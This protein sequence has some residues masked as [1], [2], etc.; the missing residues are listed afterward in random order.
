MITVLMAT[1]NGETTLPE[2]LEAFCELE[3]PDGAWKLVIVDNGSTDHTKEIIASFSQCLPLTYLFESR[4]GKNAALNTGLLSV[5]GDLVVF[6]DDDVFPKP[7][8]LKHIRSAADSHLSFSIFGGPI[9]PKWESPPED[10]I[11]EWVDLG[12]TFAI[13]FPAE[14]GPFNPHLVWGPNMAIR[15]DIFR[16]GYRFDETMGPKGPNYTMGSETALILRLT[17]AGFK[18]WHCKRAVVHH[19]IQS[20]QMTQD[21][22][23]GR[24]IRHGRGK[25][26]QEIQDSPSS[27]ALL[28]RIP[29]SL[30]LKILAQS[31]CVGLAK[32]SGDIEKIFKAR[33][34]LNYL[35]GR[36][37]EARLILRERAYSMWKALTR[38]LLLRPTRVK[39][40][41]PRPGDYK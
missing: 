13:L 17:K 1:Y 22:V 5:S 36:A 19:M 16:N 2:V 14:E 39:N 20:S 10:W 28:L 6:T 38:L 12:T 26:R 21:W 23:L 37:F 35:K 30:L 4:R 34:K 29:R 24:A 3:S 27:L 11:L 18:V 7:D 32:W 41:R 9:L 8:W 31:L 33:W 25:Y 15:S 40:M